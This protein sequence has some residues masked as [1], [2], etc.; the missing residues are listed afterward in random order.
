MIFM[1]RPRNESGRDL[2]RFVRE[3]IGQSGK[4]QTDGNIIRKDGEVVGYLD[5]EGGI[6]LEDSDKARVYHGPLMK[7]YDR[8]VM[9][10]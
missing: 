5:R 9:N 3:R 1:V 2:V 10:F 4:F 6:E 7:L 8:A